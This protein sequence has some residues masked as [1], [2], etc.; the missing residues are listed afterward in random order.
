MGWETF[1]VPNLIQ[2]GGS[3]FVGGVISFL[4]RRGFRQVQNAQQETQQSAENAA[5]SAETAGLHAKNASDGVGAVETSSREMGEVLV[6]LAGELGDVKHQLVEALDVKEHLKE[7]NDNLFG[8][9]ALAE[10]R[11]NAESSERL[12]EQDPAAPDTDETTITGRHRLHTSMIKT[13]QDDGF[14]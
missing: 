10:A 3:A 6:L 11:R 9:L 12:P 14:L 4:L 5:Q 8:A 7:R 1:W 13:Q 2:W